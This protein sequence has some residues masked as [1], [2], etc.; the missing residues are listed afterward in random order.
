L[1]RALI[2]QAPSISRCPCLKV[3]YPERLR[4]IEFQY[5]LDGYYIC[6]RSSVVWPG[7]WEGYGWAALSITQVSALPPHSPRKAHH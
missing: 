5:T 3:S 2:P 4:A 6:A 1:I 7:I